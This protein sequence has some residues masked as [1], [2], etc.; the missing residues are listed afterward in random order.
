[1]LQRAWSTAL[2]GGG[3]ECQV[4]FRAHAGES[5][6]PVLAAE[7]CGTS[8]TSQ[9]NTPR[10]TQSIRDANPD[11]V[12]ADSTRRGYVVLDIGADTLEAR[13][14]VVDSVKRPEMAIS[15]LATFTVA[16]GQ[17]GIRK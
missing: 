5:S 12:F 17:A 15:T 4:A 14:R 9:G 11:I 3:R 16:A 7:F 1:M 2:A 13:L 10:V 6:S 8:I